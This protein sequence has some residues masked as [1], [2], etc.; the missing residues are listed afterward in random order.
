MVDP[1]SIV[2]GEPAGW[3]SAAGMQWEEASVWM[4]WRSLR[5]NIEGANKKNIHSLGSVGVVNFVF[6]L[7]TMVELDDKYRED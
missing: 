3:G 4:R 2:I 7:Q 5:I 6:F 1:A